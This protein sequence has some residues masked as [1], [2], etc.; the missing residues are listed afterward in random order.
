MVSGI[1]ITM[2]LIRGRRFRKCVAVV[3][4]HASIFMAK[5][6]YWLRGLAPVATRHDDRSPVSVFGQARHGALIVLVSITSTAVKLF[7]TRFCWRRFDERCTGP[8]VRRPIRILISL[9]VI[10]LVVKV[11]R[12][13]LLVHHK[14][15]ISIHAWWRWAHHNIF[16]QTFLDFLRFCSISLFT[17]ERVLKKTPK[18]VHKIH[19]SCLFFWRYMD[20]HTPLQLSS[21]N[22]NF[23][24]Y[25]A[26][27]SFLLR[28]DFFILLFHSTHEIIF[29]QLICNFFAFFFL[30]LH[31][32][33]TAI[34][35][36]CTPIKFLAN[37]GGFAEVLISTIVILN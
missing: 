7:M 17:Q 21:N 5:R 27:I 35:L 37:V 6:L 34:L 1:V 30:F 32:R 8:A 11:R 3:T 2:H 20:H 15:S 19:F 36:I 9:L 13:L 12:H 25:S 10:V 24:H 23:H 18:I 29:F 14:I 26:L 33:F 31:S 22:H 28:P 4:P 16:H